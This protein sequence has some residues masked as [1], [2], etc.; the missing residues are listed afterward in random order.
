[1]VADR[2]AFNG[3]FIELMSDD[4]T[5]DLTDEIETQ[6]LTR[7]Y[8][9]E[10]RLSHA[11]PVVRA[12]NE[13]FDTKKRSFLQTLLGSRSNVLLFGCV[14]LICFFILVFSRMQGRD[15]D[16]TLGGNI[17]VLELL[18]EGDVAIL[19]IDKKAPQRGEV[20]LGP[21]DIVIRPSDAIEGDDAHFWH[22]VNFNPVS[23]QFFL[24]SIPF[25]GDDFFVSFTA[26]EEHKSVR[27]RYLDT[28]R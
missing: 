13:N 6:E 15:P 22:R 26:G 24:I 28:L 18:F 25:A 23:E 27:L 10:R 21:V 11:S 7:Y 12:M 17:L 2:Q 8:S 5:Q 1:M 14:I 4:K 3:D 19:S 9:R 20:Y 16:F